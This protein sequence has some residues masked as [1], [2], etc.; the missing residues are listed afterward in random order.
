MKLEDDPLEV[1]QR[2]LE[3]PLKRTFASA[4]KLAEADS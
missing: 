2:I 1:A 3:L 4:R